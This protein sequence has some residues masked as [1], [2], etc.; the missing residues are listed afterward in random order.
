VGFQA[1]WRSFSTKPITLIV[2]FAGGPTDVSRTVAISMSK[3][4]GQTIVVE[5]KLARRHHRANYVASSARRLHDPDPSQRHGHRRRYRKQRH[6]TS[7]TGH[8]FEIGERMNG[9]LRYNAA[10]CHAV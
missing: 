5:N 4:L 10:R 3:S 6:R 7:S 8:V 9:S 1:A 2:P